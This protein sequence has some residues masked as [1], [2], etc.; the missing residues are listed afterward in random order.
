M[1][2][3]MSREVLEVRGTDAETYVRTRTG[4][5][6]VQSVD[7]DGDRVERREPPDEAVSLSV[8]VCADLELPDEI[9]ED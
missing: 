8:A 6:L 4:W 1:N 2:E 7:F 5:W 3:Y 9:F